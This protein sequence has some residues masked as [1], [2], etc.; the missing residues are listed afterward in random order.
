MAPAEPMTDSAADRHAAH[1][2]DARDL[3]G[4]MDPLFGRG[5]PREVL[6]ELGADA[7]W[8]E[9][10]DMAAIAT[11]M[12]YL[13]INYYS[14]HVASVGAPFDAQ[15]QGL[16]VTDMG[17]EICPRALTGLLLRLQRDYALPPVLITENGAAFADTLVDGQVHDTDRVDYL[18]T[19]IAA[20]A[21]SRDQGV[22]MAGYMVWSLMDNFEWASGYA[23]RF[24]IVHVDYASLQRTPKDS[25]LWLRGFLQQCRTRTAGGGA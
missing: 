18:R 6:E 17:W 23:K 3:R 15:A 12:D 13:G 5:Y 14:R 24:G 2:C 11:P 16:P 19:H 10:G 7:P 21:D 1:L 20:V 25:A 4:Y 9:P 22:P 8:V